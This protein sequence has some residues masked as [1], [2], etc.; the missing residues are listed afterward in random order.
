MH[1]LFPKS[2]RGTNDTQAMLNQLL[3]CWN[4]ITG[5]TVRMIPSVERALW[6][7]MQVYKDTAKE[8]LETTLN[9]AVYRNKRSECPWQLRFQKFFDGEYAHF[10][11]IRAEAEQYEK[12][13][14][15]KRRQ[16]MPTRGEVELSQMRHEP[17]PE[18]RSEPAKRISTSLLSEAIKAMEKQ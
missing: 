17:T 10:E 7:Y 18:S 14:A 4:L 5:Q 8:D 11:S 1:N 12:A 3:D 6:D 16:A 9:Y 15:A 2:M 13:R